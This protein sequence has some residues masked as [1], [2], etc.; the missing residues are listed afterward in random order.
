M[1]TSWLQECNRKQPSSL[2]HGH[3]FEQMA[4]RDLEINAPTT[5]PV[6]ELP[7]IGAP[8]CAAIAE[9]GLLHARKDRVELRVGNVERVVMAPEVGTIVEEEGQ[10]SLTLTGAKCASTPL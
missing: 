8:R 4:V 3:Q 7:V 5:A 9:A 6:I 1:L 2:W 10:L